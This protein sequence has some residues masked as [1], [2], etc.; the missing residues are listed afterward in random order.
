MTPDPADTP[1]LAEYLTAIRDA[2]EG[3]TYQALASLGPV[4]PATGRPTGPS[5]AMIHALATKEL[6]AFPA[7]GYIHGLAHMIAAL[8]S[9]NPTPDAIAKAGQAIVNACTRSL[10]LPPP[11][12]DT[13]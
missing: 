1:T 9:A 4:D 11:G 6:R 13:P 5:P 2:H 3:L 12:P 8:D 7:P 10:G